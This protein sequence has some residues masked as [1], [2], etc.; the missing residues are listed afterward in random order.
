MSPGD[1]KAVFIPGA[2]DNSLESLMELRAKALK[3]V[4]D[5]ERQL[6]DAQREYAAASHE[7]KL[8]SAMVEHRM[9]RLS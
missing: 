1:T 8:W 3:R 9:H 7:L 2:M 5:A 6:Q 4:A